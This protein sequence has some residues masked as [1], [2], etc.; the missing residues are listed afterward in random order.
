MLANK[1]GDPSDPATAIGPLVNARQYAQIF[2]PVLCIL[3]YRD[4]DEA[5]A[6]A[7]DTDYGFASG[8][9]LVCGAQCAVATRH[10]SLDV[11]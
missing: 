11:R 6:I 10:A 3:T 5:V 2:G 8:G 1:V 9:I 4:E 7:N